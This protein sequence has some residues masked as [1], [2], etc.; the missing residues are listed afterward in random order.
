MK[1]TGIVRRIDEL[2]RVVV[3][4]EIRRTLR[5]HEGDALEIYASA[6]GEIVLKKYSLLGELPTLA[7]ACA[8]A[9]ARQLGEIVWICDLERVIAVAGGP[10]K[11]ILHGRLHEELLDWLHSALMGAP[12]A[13]LPDRVL[14]N[15]VPLAAAFAVPIVTDGMIAGGVLLM[16][17]ASGKKPS[18]GSEQTIRALAE[19]LG[20][21]GST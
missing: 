18:E 15:P 13:K 17:A 9:A 6:Q 4:K 12:E 16:R 3:P 19:V 20:T 1:G 11:G 7:A 21:Y 2:G 5:I 8:A 14:E 10:K